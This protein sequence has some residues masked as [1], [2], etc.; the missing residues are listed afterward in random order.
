MTDND[1]KFYII[2]AIFNK[3][4]CTSKPNH[5]NSFFTKKTKTIFVMHFDLWYAFFKYKLSAVYIQLEN[6]KKDK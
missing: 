5:A 1:L 2:C 4:Y 6:A 3:R